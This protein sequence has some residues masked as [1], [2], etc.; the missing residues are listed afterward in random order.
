[1]RESAPRKSKPEPFHHWNFRLLTTFGLSA[2]TP[3]N[4]PY[5][6][7]SRRQITSLI[8]LKVR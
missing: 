7:A 4:S 3:V 8:L 1:M 6:E 5:Y 2:G